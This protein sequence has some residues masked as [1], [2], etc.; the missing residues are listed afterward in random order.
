MHVKEHGCIISLGTH[1]NCILDIAARI[2]YMEDGYLAPLIKC[3]NDH[4]VII[5]L[6]LSDH[7]NRN[8]H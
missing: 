4:R 3:R 7:Q 6:R 1:D 2:M 8:K 5:P